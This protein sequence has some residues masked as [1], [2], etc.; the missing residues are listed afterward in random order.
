MRARG[1]CWLEEDSIFLADGTVLA[2][3]IAWYDYSKR[4][5]QTAEWTPEQFARAKPD[6]I[7][8]GRRIAWGHT[9]PG[10][11]GL[12]SDR[13]VARLERLSGDPA[14][15]RILVATHVPVFERQLTGRRGDDP[16]LESYYANLTLGRRLL[17]FPKVGAVV[18]GHTHRGLEPVEVPQ[19]GRPPV[20][21]A[22][23]GSDYGDPR[24]V[25]LE[26]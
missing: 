25:T 6:V 3:S 12:V 11:A 18:S 21:L 10:F 13:L 23:L 19:E 22:N 4:N 5:P 2:G 7:N 16:V 9:D 24:F 17:A 15:R 1:Q 8:D 20:T 14:V 26:L